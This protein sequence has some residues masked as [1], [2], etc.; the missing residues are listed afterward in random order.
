M[1]IHIH[2]TKHFLL[3][4]P[5]NQKIAKAELK[6][7][8][9]KIGLFSINISWNELI[10]FVLFYLL[11]KVEYPIKFFNKEKMFSNGK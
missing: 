1:T 2:N 4:Y 5:I 11:L 8:Q 10:I 9:R 3:S 6:S 7:Y